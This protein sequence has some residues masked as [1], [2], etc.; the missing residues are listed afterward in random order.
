MNIVLAE[1]ARTQYLLEE[2]LDGSDKGTILEALDRLAGAP[3]GS[4]LVI[5]TSQFDIYLVRSGNTTTIVKDIAPKLEEPNRGDGWWNPNEP[6]IGPLDPGGH[7]DDRSSSHPSSP[8]NTPDISSVLKSSA[9]T[10]QFLDSQADTT[11]VAS[12]A[13]L[14]HPA[15]DASYGGPL[16][17]NFTAGDVIDLHGLAAAL[18]DCATTVNIQFIAAGGN[19]LASPT[20]AT[21]ISY[22]AAAVHARVADI[23]PTSLPTFSIATDG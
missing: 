3:S 20:L 21:G 6:L 10:F 1:D 16:L 15:D 12:T 19:A 2:L 8:D 11:I 17:D 23:D 22:S 14:S 18:N 7:D 13:E 5:Q 9:S 4:W